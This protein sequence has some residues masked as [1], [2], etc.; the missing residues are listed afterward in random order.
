MKEHFLN[1]SGYYP[2]GDYD[3]V[4]VG[5]E[6][7]EQE[8]Y[9]KSFFEVLSYLKDDK[10]KVKEFLN[11][12][13][14]VEQIENNNLV[15]KDNFFLAKELFEKEYNEKFNNI[16]QGV[17][18]DEYKFN[19]LTLDEKE[20]DNL[21][22]NIANGDFSSLEIYKREIDY[23]KNY[24]NDYNENSIFQIKDSVILNEEELENTFR[25]KDATEALFEGINLLKKEKNIEVEFNLRNAD[26]GS[27]FYLVSKIDDG[28]KEKTEFEINSNDLGLYFDKSFKFLALNEINIASDLKVSG[29][30]T[31]EEDK[32]KYNTLEKINTSGFYDI[33]NYKV[34]RIDYENLDNMEVKSLTISSSNSN[35]EI[36]LT[37]IDKENNQ[38]NITL[39]QG[40]DS[41]I[42][43]KTYNIVGSLIGSENFSKI[44]TEIKEDLKEI[45]KEKSKDKEI[46]Y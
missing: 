8:N 19:T 2:Y 22:E 7:I 23:K 31:Y 38:N 11:D 27:N 4:E 36:N 6:Y 45:E 25:L 46:E 35:E 32:E 44:Y 30:S 1:D 21:Y 20:F 10:E 29:F 9:D 13:I 26:D 28:Y 33:E 14:F 41:E 16:E 17:G 5:K 40:F 18:F 3:Y 39:E 37:I 24:S 12:I 34:S 42:R 43:E 15:H